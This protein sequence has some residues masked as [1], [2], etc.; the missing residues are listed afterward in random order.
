MNRFVRGLAGRVA[1]TAAL[2]L[3]SACLDV[4]E[5]RAERDASVGRAERGG[6]RVE[7]EHGLAAVRELAPG[8]LELWA[9]APTLRANLTLPPGAPAEWVLRVRNA[10]PDAALR[11]FDA[12][13]SPVPAEPLEA[14][15]GTDRRFLVRA[16]PGQTLRIVL[17]AP[18]ADADAPF[19]FLVFAD[20]QDAIDRVQDIFRRMNTEARARFVMM[21]GDITERGGA[22]ELERF[23][24]EQLGLRLPIFVTLG[25]H[26]LGESEVL[27]HSYFG[28]GSQSFTFHGARFT[29][30]DSASATIDPKVYAWLD[31]WLEQ[32]RGH[33]HFVFAHIAPVEPIGVRNGCFSSRAEAN[34]LI[35]RMGRAGVT[36]SFYG[37]VHSY[38]TFEHAGIPVFISGGGGAIPE[39][40][41]GIG[42][43]Y[44][45]ID[46]DPRART[47]EKRLVRVD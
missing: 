24:Q 20:V 25:N 1:V 43:H 46:V 35:A 23:Q 42:R 40:F 47:F 7:V 37:H 32:G 5:E 19:Q 9:N 27:Y 17:A 22:E 29:T 18:D 2:V 44:L 26:E 39:R 30:L 11:A 21:A 28:R 8:R 41:D 4:A 31:T 16:E 10:M 15:F 36:A 6:L 38:Y 13:G 12:A 14:A 45:A 3:S 33:A 34:R